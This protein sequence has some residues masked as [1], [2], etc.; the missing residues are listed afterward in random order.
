MKNELKKILNPYYT[1]LD[2]AVKEQNESFLAQRDC[3]KQ[4]GFNGCWNCKIKDSECAVKRTRDMI[5]GRIELLRLH[6]VHKVKD[7][8]AAE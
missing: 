5:N 7:W 3:V 6:I 8:L 2:E 4:K 1:Q